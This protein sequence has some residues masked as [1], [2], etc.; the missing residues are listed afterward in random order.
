MVGWELVHEQPKGTPLDPFY[1]PVAEIYKI[2]DRRWRLD[3]YNEV[4]GRYFT[5]LKAAKAMGIALHRMDND[6]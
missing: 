3:M 1:S 5:T 6:G 4:Q 2:T